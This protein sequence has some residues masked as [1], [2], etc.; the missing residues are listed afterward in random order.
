MTRRGLTRLSKRMTLGRL[1]HSDTALRKGLSNRPG[2][3][4]RRNLA[5]LAGLLDQVERLIGHRVSITSGYRSDELNRLVG[6]V[7]RSQ[8]TRGQAA[9]FI[10]SR[11]GPPLCIALAIA[12]SPIRFDQLIYEYG[13]AADGGWIHLSFAHRPRRRTLTICSGKRGYRRGLHPCFN[14]S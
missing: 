7:P 8:H 4:E 6:G 5:G 11:Y 14:C 13:C 12:A 10:C 3:S 9:D 2:A 1:T